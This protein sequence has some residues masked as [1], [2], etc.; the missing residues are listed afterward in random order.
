M[1]KI[2]KLKEAL[3][4]AKKL[5]EQNKSIVLAGGCFD[6]LHVAHV[7]FLEKAKQKGDILFVLLES[8]DNVRKLKGK[9]RP[10]NS[11]KNRAMIL[12]ALA[13][14]DYVVRLSNLKTN[15][16]YDAI[17][18]KLRPSIIAITAKDPN[19]VHK[20]RQANQINGKVV[21]V[22]QR[23]S[24]QSTTRLAKLIEGEI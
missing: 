7:K 10:I 20:I 15:T 11:Q 13:F 21:C 12:S 16:Q 1:N 6:I 14:V 23:I 19:I 24:D 17:V 2:L 22:L 4:I 3:Q 9:N 18:R 5:R 8:D